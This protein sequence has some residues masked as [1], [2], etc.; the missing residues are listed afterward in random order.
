MAPLSIRVAQMSD[1]PAILALGD[2]LPAFGPTTRTAGEIAS[3]ERAALAH[4]LSNPSPASRL[5]VAEQPPHG[6]IGVILLETRVDYFTDRPHGYVAILA[7]ARE[8]EGRGVGRALLK[9]AEDWGRA[10]GF[11]KLALAVFAD[12]RRAKGFYERQGW[13]PELE[14]WYKQLGV[15]EGGA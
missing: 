11:T 8:A 4:G 13:S 3:R 9:A 5:L 15:D 1:E 14:T 6:V 2:R 12:N 7:V 10:K